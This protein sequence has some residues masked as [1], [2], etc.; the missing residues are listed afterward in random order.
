[1]N[2]ADFFNKLFQFCE[3]GIEIRP[4]PG[5]QGFFDIED[6]AG[7]KTH[8]AEYQKSNLYFGV[9]TRDGKGGCKEKSSPSC[10]S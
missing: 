3:G 5:K 1:M 6:I 10:V 7:I 9:A 4:L 8:C 2:R